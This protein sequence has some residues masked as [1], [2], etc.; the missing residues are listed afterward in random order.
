MKVHRLAV[1]RVFLL[2]T[3]LPVIPPPAD[4]P[5]E[6]ERRRNRV[7]EELQG[8][9]NRFVDHPRRVDDIQF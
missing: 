6:H 4:P 1:G 3:L 5:S 2:A 7:I 9:R 8:T